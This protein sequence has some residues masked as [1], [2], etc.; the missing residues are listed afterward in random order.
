[1]LRKLIIA[2]IL[3][4]MISA[5]ST[6]ASW[7]ASSTESRIQR[8]QD[9]YAAYLKNDKVIA[10]A[11]LA[12]YNNSEAQAL[13]ARAIWYMEHGYMIYGHYKYGSTG[14]IDCSIFTALV[15]KD[16]GYTIT[17]ASR[18]YPQVGKKVA[19]VYSRK[20]P[21]SDK[22]ELVGTEN[23]R[24]GDV[25]TFWKEDSDGSG[26]HIGHVA[27]YMGKIN[28]EPAIIQTIS[29][30]PTAIGITTSFKYWYGEHFVEARRILD[31]SS[32]SPEKPWQASL[33]VIPDKYQLPPQKTIVQPAE[34]FL[35]NKATS[36]FR[37]IA[38]HWAEEDIRKLMKSGVLDGYPDGTFQPDRP[39]SRAEFAAA[40]VKAFDISKKTGK[41]FL[42]TSSHWAKDYISSAAAGGIVSGYNSTFFGPDDPITREQMAVMIV[43]AAEIDADVKGSLKAA[44]A[45]GAAISDWAQDA[46]LAAGQKAIIKG[47]TDNTYKPGRGANRAEAAAVISRALSL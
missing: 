24:P 33:P 47:Y 26:T 42:D 7:A 21:G 23:L 25:F 9:N 40:L 28:G 46:V 29:G 39:I 19:G 45:D 43:E 17:S 1:M 5:F 38:A 8:Y 27:L 31:D 13:V 4:V 30:R 12:G 3:G 22:Y 20:I 37:D 44:Y 35:S 32:Q 15:Y 2:I 41:V 11:F 36:Q 16:F 34:K 14:Y 6:S 18:K 10:D